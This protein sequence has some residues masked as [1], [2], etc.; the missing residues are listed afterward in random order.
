M[1]V[2]GKPPSMQRYRVRSD[3]RILAVQKCCTTPPLTHRRCGT[4]VEMIGGMI[5]GD[6]AGGFVGGGLVAG[7]L[8]GGGFVGKGVG[9]IDDVAVRVNCCFGRLVLVGG[10]GVRVGEAVGVGDK[11]AVKT[12]VAEGID[13][14]V[15][16]RDAVTVLKGIA[17]AS[18]AVAVSALLVGVAEPFP[19]FGITRSA[20]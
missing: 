8:V 14:L 20:L 12:G 13:V 3:L 5:G 7:G 9:W 6:V 17:D 2:K 10:M 18:T 1:S 16:A 11:V 19:V 4:I 15:A